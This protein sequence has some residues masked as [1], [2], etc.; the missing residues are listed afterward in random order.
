MT[1]EERRRIHKDAKDVIENADSVREA[2]LVWINQGHQDLASKAY[3]I[4]SRVSGIDSVLKAAYLLTITEKASEYR[5]IMVEQLEQEKLASIKE[6]T[7]VEIDY[8]DYSLQRLAI[9]EGKRRRTRQTSRPKSISNDTSK[10][11][12]A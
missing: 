6:Y 3:A 10:N 1:D 2:L 12:H 11:E 5:E 9:M 8:F 7:D 4:K